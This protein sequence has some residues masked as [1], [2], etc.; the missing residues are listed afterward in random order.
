MS[1]AARS[2]RP[3]RC[4]VDSADV[5]VV[6][7]DDV[8]APVDERLGR[9]PRPSA[10]IWA[11]RPITRRRGTPSGSPKSRTELDP[12]DRCG[13]HGGHR[14]L[15]LTA[16][17]TRLAIDRCIGRTKDPGG[18]V[19]GMT[20]FGVHTGLQNTTVDELR[21]LWTR[22]EDLGFDWISIWDHFYSA[23][24]N[25]YDVPRSR[26]R[27]TRRWRATRPV[28]AAARSSTARATGTRRCWPT[29][30][31][32]STTCRAAVPTSA[33]VP[34]GRSTSTTP[35][36]SRS[37]DA[38]PRLDILEESAAVRPR[39][40]ARRDGRVQGRAL[41]AHRRPNEPRPVQAAPADLDRR[42][43]ASSARC[44]S[45]PGTRTGGTCRSSRPRSSPT[46]RACW[47]SAAPRSAA[48]RARSAAR[49]TSASPSTRTRSSASSASS[50]RRHGQAC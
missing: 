20:A 26:R 3:S 46:R 16:R 48:T 37:R 17:S 49:S 36:A 34:G 6:E 18:T 22:I 4:L 21:S 30:S 19:P 45:P 41:H 33:S 2:G 31:P 28:C 9:T 29:R 13:G 44:A 38:G 1:A 5:A 10:T 11:P 27:S 50:P 47:P 35:T 23:D 42:S 12:V 25:G 14:R 24:F 8:E 43:A 32:P 39:P 7:A 15:N 40:A